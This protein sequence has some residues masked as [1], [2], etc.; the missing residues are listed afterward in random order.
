MWTLWSKRKTQLRAPQDLTPP[1]R[2]KGHGQDRPQ[3]DSADPLPA[4]TRNCQ[5]GALERD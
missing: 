3:T 2:A 4:Q 5:L 1:P